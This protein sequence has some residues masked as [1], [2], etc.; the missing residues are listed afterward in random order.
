MDPAA[1]Y[2]H[3]TSPTEQER[4]SLLNRL[5]NDAAMRELSLRG[6]ERIVDFGCGLGQ[7]SRQMARAAGGR[8]LAIERSPE[9]LAEADRLAAVAKEEHLLELRQGDVGDPPLRPEEWGRFDLAHARFV[10]EHVPDP[11]AVVRQMVR[12]VRPGGRIVLQDDDHEVL[13]CYPEP[14][15]FMPLWRAYERTYDR[16]GCDPYVGRRLASLLHQAGAA[17][18]R[19]TFVFFGGCAG[20]PGFPGLVRNMAGLLA[21]ARERIVGGG[22]LGDAEFDQGLSGLSAWATRPDAAFWYGIFWAE[23][24]REQ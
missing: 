22:L 17:P 13:R 3:G 12:A 1:P 14:P 4:L 20:D 19:C 15:G 5:I 24:V 9:Q 16:L 11:L 21:G 10:L 18:R 2:L 6:G 23:G 7:L 8:V